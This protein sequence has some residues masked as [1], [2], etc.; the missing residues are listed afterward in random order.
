MFKKKVITVML[1]VLLA[2]CPLLLA[3]NVS[4]QGIDYTDNIISIMEKDG[5][6]VVKVELPI[7][8]F[9][10]FVILDKVYGGTNVLEFP[11]LPGQDIDVYFESST[12]L[13]STYIPDGTVV[14]CIF[15]VNIVQNEKCTAKLS[16]RQYNSANKIM[17]TGTGGPVNVPGTGSVTTQCV[18]NK[19]TETTA[20]T[21]FANLHFPA[22]SYG[23]TKVITIKSCVM[24]MTIASLVLNQAQTGKTN[25]ILKAVETKLEENGQKLEDLVITQQETNEKLDGVIDQQQQSNEKLDG[26][27]DQQQ[28]SNEKLD[29]IQ[30]SLDTQIQDEID[31]AEEMAESASAQVEEAIPDK[32]V[33]LLPAMQNLAASLSYQG[34]EAKLPFPK[35]EMPAIPGV[36]A[37]FELIPAQEIDFTAFVQMIPTGM[38]NVMRALCD[39]AIVIWAFRELYGIYQYVIALKGGGV[40]V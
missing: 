39:I 9:S 5:L 27:I 2:V 21:I 25:K 35:V 10:S 23:H 22:L 40:D 15:D 11:R 31:K 32:S 13:D 33:E 28:Q 30:D 19:V 14:S 8:D 20:F 1:A 36:C 24:E 29:G 38:I 3:S 26:V 34:T 6:S 7:D 17:S 18:L 16:Y 12:R 4:A 37:S